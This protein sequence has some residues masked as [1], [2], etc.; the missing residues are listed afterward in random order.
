MTP[1]GGN[2]T[3]WI[4]GSNSVRRASQRSMSRGHQSTRPQ[5]RDMSTAGT[6]ASA[7]V[8][9]TASNRGVGTSRSRPAPPGSSRWPRPG[10]AGRPESARRPPR[11]RQRTKLRVS[12][13]KVGPVRRVPCFYGDSDSGAPTLS[14]ATRRRLR[15]HGATTSAFALAE[16]RAASEPTE[17]PPPLK[18]WSARLVHRAQ[19]P[20]QRFRVRASRWTSGFSGLFIGT[21]SALPY[22]HHAGW[23]RARGPYAAVSQSSLRSR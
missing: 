4:G 16:V 3:P 14:S 5:S 7:P 19:A 18:R 10:P 13:P 9:S 1:G 12:Y 17:P 11:L 2:L 22:E 6:P 15:I 23:R 8:G 20:D 21:Y